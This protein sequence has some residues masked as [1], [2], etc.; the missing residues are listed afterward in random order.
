[1]GGKLMYFYAQ[2]DENNICIGISQLSGQVEASNMV[3]I[4]NLDIDK[5]WRKYENGQWS[6]EKYEPQTTAP[7]A[8]FEQMQQQLQLM[9]LALDELILGGGL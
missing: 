3:P 7:L 8:E 1:M 9:Q 4:D 6:V 2:L 5:I